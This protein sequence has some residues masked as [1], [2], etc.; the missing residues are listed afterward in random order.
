MQPKCKGYYLIYNVIKE[1][2]SGLQLPNLVTR[3]I[4]IS[5]LTCSPHGY[6][7]RMVN[8]LYS[9]FKKLGP[10]GTGKF[11]LKDKTER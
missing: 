5:F 8:L 7:L 3:Q 11:A 9:V 4:I 2:T 10:E 1:E 6:F